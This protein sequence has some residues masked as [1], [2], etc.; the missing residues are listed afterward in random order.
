MWRFRKVACQSGPTASTSPQT[1]FYDQLRSFPM[2]R[3]SFT[4]HARTR[5]GRDGWSR[6]YRQWLEADSLEAFHRLGLGY[7]LSRVIRHE[8]PHI[9]V[10]SEIC[11]TL[12]RNS[13]RSQGKLGL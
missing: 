7:S 10:S 3:R 13:H 4:V 11:E 9:G 2:R 8:G 12:R 6:T 5:H 1:S